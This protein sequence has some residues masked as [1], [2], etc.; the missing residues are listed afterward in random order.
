MKKIASCFFVLS[1]SFQL[2]CAQNDFRK[3]YVIKNNGDTL[4][5]FV[6]NQLGF[7]N[8]ESCIFK[9][10]ESA[11]VQS[12][13]PTEIKEYRFLND[14]RYISKAIVNE[15]GNETMV[16]LE[17]IAEGKLSL[18]KDKN[19]YWVKKDNDPLVF[20][21]VEKENVV[22]TFEGK[23]RSYYSHGYII[24]LSGLTKDCAKDLGNLENL[25]YSEKALTKLINNYNRFMGKPSMAFKDSKNWIE[26]SFMLLN[27]MNFSQLKFSTDAF[28]HEYLTNPF[29]LS[30]AYSFGAGAEFRF[31]KI[32]DKLSL[33]SE[34]SFIGINYHSKSIVMNGGR[35]ERNDV[36]INFKS[37][38]IP[39]GL[40]LDLNNKPTSPYLEA[41]V[42]ALY[43][44]KQ[45][46]VW[47]KEIQFDN[48]PEIETEQ[49]EATKPINGQFGLWY[50]LG[51]K[52]T[53]AKKASFF[54]GLRHELSSG[55][56][57]SINAYDVDFQINNFQVIAGIKFR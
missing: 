18:Y 48:E 26:S 21:S 10:K 37:L 52:T 28:Y 20:L 32:N 12:F 17:L 51:I 25:V 56:I 55:K 16:F 54:I 3:A 35:T 36:N 5:G 33:I 47:I 50:G 22:Y 29:E 43:H 45:S 11:K 44:L 8:F 19:N 13:S 30:Y 57:M 42:S 49:T 46:S 31:S 41:G 1:L 24:T 38:K 39:I 34:V 7:N 9:E 40:K 27:S 2:V 4:N 53:L 15:S 23:E 14:K 6:N